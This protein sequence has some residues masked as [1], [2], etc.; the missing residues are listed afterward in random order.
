MV[1]LLGAGMYTRFWHN[2][3]RW[4]IETKPVSLGPPRL[5]CVVVGLKK[6]WDNGET[7]NAPMI[8]TAAFWTSGERRDEPHP[9][10]AS[11]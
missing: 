3:P 2:P 9:A 8:G 6:F 1:S 4:V 11:A 5:G 7:V 10:L